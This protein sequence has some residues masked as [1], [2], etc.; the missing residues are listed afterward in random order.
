MSTNIKDEIIKLSKQNNLRSFT[1]NQVE[2]LISHIGS[3]DSKERD[4][5]TYELMYQGFSNNLFTSIQKRK[6]IEEIN[7]HQI[8]FADIGSIN[9]LVFQRSFT[10]LIG[11]LILSDDVKSRTLTVN[12]RKKW[13]SNAV[14]YLRMERDWRGFVPEKGWAHAVAHGSDLMSAAIEHPDFNSD[15][16]IL[17]TVFLVIDSVKEPLVDDEED[18]LAMTIFSLH[19]MGRITDSAIIN[20]FEKTDEKLWS[21]FDSAQNYYYYRL[22]FW[23][24]FLFSVSVLVP[25]IDGSIKT[26]ISRYYVNMGY[27]N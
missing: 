27:I 14:K 25:S 23:K 3:L 17:E 7:N 9:D 1:D 11:A 13:F 22:S 15:K 6:I 5:Y 26:L 4:Q 16:H 12:E 21:S 20:W 10:A 8:L 18:R 24:S 19:K 2:W